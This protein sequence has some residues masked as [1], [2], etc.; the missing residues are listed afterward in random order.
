MNKRERQG[1]FFTDL[2]PEEIIILETCLS[3]R[4]NGERVYRDC[5]NWLGEKLFELA[6]KGEV[7]DCYQGHVGADSYTYR[8]P[9]QRSGNQADNPVEAA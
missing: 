6:A 8:V 7:A 9:Q 3:Q 1:T 2:T 5:L 4:P